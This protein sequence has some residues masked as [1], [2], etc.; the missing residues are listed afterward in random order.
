MAN[1]GTFEEMTPLEITEN[2][3]EGTYGSQM[4]NAKILGP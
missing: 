4:K 3:H 2:L 1:S